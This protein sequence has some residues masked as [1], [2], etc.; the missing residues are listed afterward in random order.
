MTAFRAAKTVSSLPGTLE[1]DTI[2]L[3][4]VGSGFELYCSDVTGNIAHQINRNNIRFSSTTP[5]D[6]LLPFWF[7]PDSGELSIFDGTQ[8]VLTSSNSPIEITVNTPI[9]IQTKIGTTAQGNYSPVLGDRVIVSFLN[10]CDVDSP[11][12]NVDGSGAKMIRLGNEQVSS[13][14][15]GSNTAFIVSMWFDGNS[16]QLYGLAKVPSAFKAGNLLFS[17]VNPGPDWVLCD[18]S[19][20]TETD[21]LSPLLPDGKLPDFSDSPISMYIS[22]RKTGSNNVMS[23][24]GFDWALMSLFR[25]A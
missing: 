23:K 2:Y 14:A 20:Y 4:R 18:G 10:G 21:D 19:T 7:N 5:A 15:F 22:K 13:A 3:V 1:S 8:W 9:D 24:G 12:L 11:L 25:G 17:L 6:S 16:W